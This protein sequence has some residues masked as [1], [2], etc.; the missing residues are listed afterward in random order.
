MFV[1]SN[2]VYQW[3][4]ESGKV[5]PGNTKMSQGRASPGVLQRGA[6]KK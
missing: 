3:V 4:L 2:S 5:A 6:M 1:G